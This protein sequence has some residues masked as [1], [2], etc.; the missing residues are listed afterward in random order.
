MWNPFL[1]QIHRVKPLIL[2]DNIILTNIYETQIF[3]CERPTTNRA[4]PA[5][6]PIVKIG[7]ITCCIEFEESLSES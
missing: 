3:D 6:P 2:N 1:Y 5:R 7:S 4:Q